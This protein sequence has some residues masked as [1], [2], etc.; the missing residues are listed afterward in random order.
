[1]GARK[2]TMVHIAPTCKGCKGYEEGSN[3]FGSQSF[4]AFL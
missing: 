2:G 1:L 4:S 3:Y